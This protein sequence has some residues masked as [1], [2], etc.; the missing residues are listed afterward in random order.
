ML[1]SVVLPAP[2]D[3]MTAQLSPFRTLQSRPSS[4]FFPSY[5]TVTFLTEMALLNAPV[6]QTHA[7]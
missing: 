6:R 3:P 4:A 7:L 1:I 2:F 5:S